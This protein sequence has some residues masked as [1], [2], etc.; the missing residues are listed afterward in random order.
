MRAQ[1]P[2][3]PNKQEAP[4]A[5]EVDEADY[6]KL[7]ELKST[8]RY[9]SISRI[10]VEA[11]ESFD[12]ENLSTGARPKKQMSVRVPRSLLDRFRV[13]AKSEGISINSLVRIALQ[14]FFEGKF[15]TESDPPEATPRSPSAP[16][17]AFEQI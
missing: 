17:Q 6:S 13:A 10:I 8:G 11:L 15:G 9:S 14:S 1:N 12:L 5:F 3:S 2:D 4:F 7:C 16:S